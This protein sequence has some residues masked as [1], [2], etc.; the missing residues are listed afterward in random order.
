VPV[1]DRADG[2]L[3]ELHLRLP[4]WLRVVAA[5]ARLADLDEPLT[6]GRVA[7]HLGTARQRRAWPGTLLRSGL[8]LALLVG[9]G[10]LA[11]SEALGVREHVDAVFALADRHAG[12]PL[13]AVIVVLAFI[14][15][16]LILVPVTLLIAATAATMGPLA[17]FV[18]ALLGSAAAA[19]TTFLI[20]RAL[21]RERVRQ[22]AGRRVAALN[23][24]IGRHGVVAVALLRLVPLA[25]F[26]VVNVVA[27]VSEVRLVDFVVGSAIGLAP[28]IGFATLF[29]AQLG[30]WLRD[31][32]L[33]GLLVL[34]G[35]LAL[36]LAAG[37]FLRRWSRSRVPA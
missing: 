17:G 28:G 21:G 4:T 25:P 20:G 26:T 24:Q 31:P 18:C 30:A 16:S 37:Y 2:R 9:L 8:L 32:D 23:R 29:G 35:A 11:R 3:R 19:G 13:G 1:F 14:L 6:P 34:L 33:G 12:D 7:E 10:V 27:G 22:L 36:L 5:P 15:G